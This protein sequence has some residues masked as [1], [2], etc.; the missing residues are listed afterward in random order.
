MSIVI[1]DV[2]KN[3]FFPPPSAPYH[4][5]IF[6]KSI[7]KRLYIISLKICF[8]LS[9]LKI[10]STK[11][12]NSPRETLNFILK[13]IK[14]SISIKLPTK[15]SVFLHP[16]E[17]DHAVLMALKISFEDNIGVLLEIL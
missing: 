1:L 2:W 9:K 13:K 15:F 6:F 10:E 3:I 17:I 7:T 14:V 16:C 12:L 5:E 8:M 4:D 11:K